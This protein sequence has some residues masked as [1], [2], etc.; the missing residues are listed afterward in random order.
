MKEI[1]RFSTVLFLI[2]SVSA[3]M[4][5][6]IYSIAEPRIIEQRRLEEKRAIEEVLPET[7]EVIEKA[8]EEDLVFYKAKDAK[9]NLIAYVFIA[10]AYGYSSDIRIVVSLSPRGNIIAVKILEHSETPGI[11]SGITGGDFLNQF[12]NKN[13]TEQF[14]TITGATISST[15]VIDSIKEGSEALFKSISEPS[16]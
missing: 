7:P 15:A 1:A 4:L 8:Q 16:D 3:G 5:A 10:Q 14:D 13:I 11:G 9:G 12:K 2:C 6:F